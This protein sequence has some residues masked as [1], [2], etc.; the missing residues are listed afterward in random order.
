MALFPCSPGCVTRP[1]RFTSLHGMG[2]LIYKMCRD[3]RACFVQLLGGASKA[4]VLSI[5]Q[6]LS[7][8]SLAFVSGDWQELS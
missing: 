1:N 2:F 6:V 4:T 3:V 5:D 8:R 7:V